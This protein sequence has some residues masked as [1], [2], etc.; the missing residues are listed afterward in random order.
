MKSTGGSHKFLD[1]TK[2]LPSMPSKGVS[3]DHSETVP[4]SLRYCMQN[5]LASAKEQR[6]LMHLVQ[7]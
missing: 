1:G 4:F 7:I 6:D 3:H 2:Q 5:Q